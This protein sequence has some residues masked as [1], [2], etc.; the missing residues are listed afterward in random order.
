M[1]MFSMGGGGGEDTVLCIVNMFHSF[2]AKYP[3]FQL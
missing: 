1:E 2:Y 3:H